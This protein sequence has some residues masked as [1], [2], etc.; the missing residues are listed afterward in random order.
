M[1]KQF[2][3]CFRHHKRKYIRDKQLQLDQLNT[4]DP[5][6]FW[7]QIKKLGPR[8]SD[9]PP[10]E[11]Y[12]DEGHITADINCV[13]DTWA[14]TYGKLYVPYEDADNVFDKEFYETK[15]REL[16]MSDNDPTPDNPIL[17]E[18]I[19]L[20]EIQNSFLHAKNNKAVGLDNLP[21]EVFKNNESCIVLAVLFNKLFDTGVAPS[22][23]L[24]ALIKPI[25]KGSTSDPRLPLQYRGISLLSPVG[26]LFSCIIN[27]RIS[28]YLETNKLIVEEQNGF[29]PK[30]SCE[31]H[32]FTIS[33]LIRT[34]N[35]LKESTFVTFIDF[36]KAFDKVDRRL[37][38]LKLKYIGINGKMFN[39]IKSLYDNNTC[40]V[41]LKEFVTPWFNAST[42]IRQGDSLSPT[43]F[44]IYIN[45]LAKV[46]KEKHKGVK[47]G[48]HNCCVLLYA[49]DI[50]L[51]S[52]TS[53]ELQ[54]MINT[55]HDWCTKWRLKVNSNK[56]QVMHF[57]PQSI[58]KTTYDFKFGGVSL[59][60]VPH[61][62]YLGVILDE[63]L[64][65]CTNAR[66][67]AAAGG[68][69]L[70]K[71]Y[72]VHK[73][74]YGLGYSPFTQLFQSYVDPILTYASGVWSAKKFSFPHAIQNR[75]IRMFLGV[76]RFA[77]NLAIN[78]DMGC[79][80]AYTKRRICMLRLWNKLCCM[81][82]DRLCKKVFD[83]D[84]DICKYNW[85]RDVKKYF[86][87]LTWITYLNPKSPLILHTLLLN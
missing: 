30:R 80:S 65:F 78:G 44:S 63:H 8:S 26:K 5:A 14:N 27:A 43:L 84:Y 57:R 19:R 31:E 69:A 49:D 74:L 18:T 1:Q 48:D 9:G 24:R 52:E 60:V 16:D 79:R 39:I 33:S 64:Q 47:F 35:S 61:Y 82:N 56:S 7:R 72:A 59:S 54:A 20:N 11:V 46:L 55:V 13:L 87:A 41:M 36:E 70:G 2:D 77:P 45:D 86:P 22:V 40:A 50:A 58:T 10:L 28:M 85:T 6:E 3:A 68:R 71:I 29:R 15:L 12:D 76:H 66:T 17:N 81:D 34:R 4:S 25:P 51:L 53:E 38:L 21:Y 73:K 32:I 67:L 62:K 37:M 83:W 75:A 42:G 23:W